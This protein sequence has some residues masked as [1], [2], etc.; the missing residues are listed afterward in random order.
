MDKGIT[1]RGKDLWSDSFRIPHGCIIS[2]RGAKHNKTRCTSSP[3][4]T[5]LILRKGW[6]Q[7]Y[8]FIPWIAVLEFGIHHCEAGRS[9]VYGRIIPSQGCIKCW[10]LKVA[11]LSSQ[12]WNRVCNF[13]LSLWVSTLLTSRVSTLMGK[14]CFPANTFIFSFLQGS[15]D[16]IFWPLT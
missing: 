3:T 11:F 10:I 7:H 4:M 5:L 16:Y 12:M 9:T 2:L 1:E 15:T 8:W 13:S 14:G 6:F